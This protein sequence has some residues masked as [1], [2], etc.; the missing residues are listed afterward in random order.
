MCLC[1][2][3]IFQTCCELHP[4]PDLADITAAVLRGNILN[5]LGIVLT[6]KLKW[7][8]ISLTLGERKKKS[9]VFLCFLLS[10]AQNF[11]WETYASDLYWRFQLI[12]RKKI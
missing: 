11:G 10:L 9:L 1:F 3:E 5:C 7:T 6:S 4:P 12:R 8:Y 2:P